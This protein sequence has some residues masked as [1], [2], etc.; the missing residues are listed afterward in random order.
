MTETLVGVPVQSY[1]N[2]TAS[3]CRGRD[4]Q[5]YLV[6]CARDCVVSVC[7]ERETSV[8]VRFPEGEAGFAY[9]SLPS[10][11]GMV[12]TGA[13]KHFF[14]FDPSRGEFIRCCAVPTAECAAYALAEADD[15]GIWFANYP[16]CSLHRF[17]PGQ[18]RCE[19]V[20]R[21]DETEKYPHSMVC[22][23]TGW[24]YAGV[25]TE[26]AAIHG[27]RIRSGELRTWAAAERTKG[28]G[29]VFRGRG[30]SIYGVLNDSPAAGS[31]EAVL[32]RDGEAATVADPSVL[33]LAPSRS[34]DALFTVPDRESWVESFSLEDREVVYR[35]P[36]SGKRVRLE[37][38]YRMPGTQ[39]SPL[40]AGPD[41]RIYGGSNHPFALYIHDPREGG[42]RR[43]AG[44]S[45]LVGRPNPATGSV[46][47]DRIGGNICA[48]AWVGR[49]M[50]GAMYAGGYLVRF[51]PGAPV[52]PG[53]NP[54]NV[55]THE[56]IHRP[57]CL[58]GL[59][60]GRR[61]A[62]AGFGGYGDAGGGLCVFDTV[63][64]DDTL[65]VNRDLVPYHS[66]YCLDNLGG[67]RLVAATSAFT[68]GGARQRERSAVLFVLDAAGRMAGRPV[69]AAEGHEQVTVCLVDRNGAVHGVTN[70][71]AYFVWDP[72]AGAVVKREDVGRFGA[73]VQAGGVRAPDGALYV[74]FERAIARI[75]VDDR[76]LRL[77]HTPARPITIGG[78]A[79]GG[80]LYY[81]CGHELRRCG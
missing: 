44:R 4:G 46:P 69:V 67:G 18:G 50:Y 30:G 47:G 63:T 26:H 73:P 53:T 40:C 8:Q 25:G 76:T 15:G 45:F 64:G 23:P 24:I 81:G 17:D 16:D 79:L 78:A 77:V 54:R 5:H 58:V 7:L 72:A 74:L 3:L 70:R 80:A 68:P 22:D 27:F 75:D 49:V 56:E 62:W 14:E 1:E 38:E 13:G 43:V 42:F 11:R 57:R 9:S 48:Y 52:E 31:R 51:D 66:I 32:L 21:L 65:V 59:P 55:A 61:V 33:A 41:G 34:F 2:R 35:S 37:I 12:Y 39:L 71:S 20:A 10:S 6:I 36:A 19:S 29:I 28:S 60:D